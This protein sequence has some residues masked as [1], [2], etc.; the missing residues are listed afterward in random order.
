MH[1]DDVETYILQCDSSALI[2]TAKKV[3]DEIAAISTTQPTWETH[4]LINK[5]CAVRKVNVYN[6]DN[7]EWVCADISE[8]PREQARSIDQLLRTNNA[9]PQGEGIKQYGRDLATPEHAYTAYFCTGQTAAKQN[10]A[11]RLNTPEPPQPSPLTPTTQPED[12]EP[13]NEFFCRYTLLHQHTPQIYS[14][15]NIFL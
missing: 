5:I 9:I 6:Q 1:E 14:I 13:N 11:V 15:T 10:P 2:Q 7:E 3:R 4:A 8:T 12:E